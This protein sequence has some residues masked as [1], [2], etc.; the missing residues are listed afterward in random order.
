MDAKIKTACLLLGG[1]GGSEQAEK[2]LAGLTVVRAADLEPLVAHDEI[3]R[4]RR[5]RRMRH[6]VGEV[7]KVLQNI[8]RRMSEKRPQRVS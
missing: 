4:R 6:R 7:L 3:T 2:A 8:C 5:E 1:E